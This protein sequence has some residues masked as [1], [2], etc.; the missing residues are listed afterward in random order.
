MVTSTLIVLGRVWAYEGEGNCWFDFK[1]RVDGTDGNGASQRYS[2]GIS[3]DVPVFAVK[4]GVT[5]GV[6]TILLRER[7]AYGAGISYGVGR[8]EWIAVAVP[9]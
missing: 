6:K 1:I 7:E 3:F 2:G 5:A 9:E 8:I 4:T